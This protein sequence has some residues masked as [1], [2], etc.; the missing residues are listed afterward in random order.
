M[1]QEV[2]AVRRV[3]LLDLQLGLVQLTPEQRERLQRALVP[4]L[5]QAARRILREERQA[6]VQQ[7]AGR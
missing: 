4:V 7:H 3:T 5:T 2:G 6:A 1:G